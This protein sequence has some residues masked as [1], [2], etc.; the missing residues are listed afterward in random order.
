MKGPAR[1]LLAGMV[2]LAMSA[3]ACVGGHSVGDTTALIVGRIAGVVRARSTAQQPWTSLKVGTHLSPGSSVQVLPHGDVSL[4]RGTLSTIEMRPYGDL[5]AELRV[6]DAGSVEVVSGDVLVKADK[7]APISVT[8]QGVTAQPTPAGG[9]D[10]PV[11]RFDRR[12]SVRV[13]VYRGEATISSVTGALPI[14]P[15]REGVVASRALPRAATP[16]TVDPRDVWDQELLPDVIDIDTGLDAQS[17]GYEAVF[18][19]RLKR[20]QDIA[21]I[22]PGRDLG[23]V[24]PY[25]TTTSNGDVLIGVVFALLLE[26]RVQTA[27]A[28]ATFGA[29]VTLLDEGATWG[30]LA[31]QYL[32]A[33]GEQAL[34]DAVTRAMA[35]L[36]GDI[37]SP[38]GAVGPPSVSPST[39]PSPT[40]SKTT[41][42]SP[43]P[44]GTKAPSPSPTPSATPLP[45][46]T[47][48]VLSHLLGLC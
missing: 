25:L 30:L 41:K 15:L 28:P 1:R 45:T 10:A 48:D 2:V 33:G 18:G 47:C 4:K 19:A 5:P 20:W 29:L 27:G 31:H 6:V 9:V 3:G 24:T 38:G 40:P 34:K 11:F 44:S 16:L 36:T 23:F 21:K 14:P 43:S 46:P 12:V 26:Q 37:T 42:P 22:A 8:S 17:R 13:G 32:G 39:R 7:R 35:L